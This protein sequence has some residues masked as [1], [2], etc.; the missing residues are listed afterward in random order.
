MICKTLVVFFGMCL[1]ANAACSGTQATPQQ[2]ALMAQALMGSLSVLNQANQ[3]ARF[4]RQRAMDRIRQ[5]N[6]ESAQQWQ[7][8]Y[9][10]MPLIPP[11]S[12]PIRRAQSGWGDGWGEPTPDPYADSWS[13]DIFKPTP[14]PDPYDTARDVLEQSG[15][16]EGFE[17]EYENRQY[18]SRFGGCA[19]MYDNNPAAKE[20]CLKGL[21][22]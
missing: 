20:M 14:T 1:L 5:R 6:R 11:T 10:S 16:G 17:R 2:R 15:I 12:A 13:S 3:Q 22:R 8:G 18:R 4:S 19:N 7:Q 9:Q 21:G